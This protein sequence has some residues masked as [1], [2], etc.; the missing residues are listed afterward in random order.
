ML[1]VL[2]GLPGTGKTTIADMLCR[3]LHAT[4]VRIDTIEQALKS[5]LLLNDDV[6]AS[7][8]LI[9]YE[10]ARSNL[11]LVNTVVADAVNPLNQIREAWRQVAASA[12]S[13]ILE[14]EVV[15]SDK[16]E[17]QCRV[18]SRKADIPGH[19]LPSWDE[20]QAR[21]YEPWTTDCLRIDTARLSA[22]DAATQ[23]LKALHSRQ[24][25]A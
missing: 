14:V 8:Y 4:Y 24:K 16:A 15:C 20:V 21:Q 19:T 23:I 17:H 6:D 1:I 3:K 9:A 5:A 11:A 7:G 22:E 2:S 13:D 10:I 25:S 12:A 18:E